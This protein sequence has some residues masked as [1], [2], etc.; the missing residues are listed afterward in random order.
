MILE[1]V[2]RQLEIGEFHIFLILIYSTTYKV[3][4]QKYCSIQSLIS[5][6]KGKFKIVKKDNLSSLSFTCF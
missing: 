5:Y 4:S 6:G 3:Y 1:K 2:L